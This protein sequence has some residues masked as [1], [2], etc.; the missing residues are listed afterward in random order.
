MW[1]LILNSRSEKWCFELGCEV[2][3]FLSG[4]QTW[5]ENDLDCIA[6]AGSVVRVRS[7]LPFSK[8]LEIASQ[9]MR[10]AVVQVN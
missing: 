3:H 6:A 4:S 7:N 9:N 2:S 5:M 8:Q 10:V 1:G